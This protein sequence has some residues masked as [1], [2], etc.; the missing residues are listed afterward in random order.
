MRGPIFGVLILVTVVV[1]VLAIRWPFLWVVEALLG[2]LWALAI[3]DVRQR[4]H[5]ILRNFPLLG[6]FR[7][8][9]EMIRPEIQQYFVEGA[10]DGTPFNRERRSVVY[11]RAKGELDTLPFGTQW[12]VYAD[13]YEWIAH[14]MMPKHPSEEMPRVVIGA[15]TCKQPYSA[16]I[17]NISAMSY[18]SLSTRA[19]LALNTGARLG[20]FAHNTGEGGVSPYHQKPGG[21][22][23]WQIGTGYFGCRNAQGG[24]DPERFTQQASLPA[25]KMIEV[26][27][28][29]GAKPGHGGILPASKVSEEISAIRGVPMGQD[30]LSP[31]GHSAFHTPAELLHWIEDLRRMSGGKPVGFKLCVGRQEEFMSV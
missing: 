5:A 27:L 31:P 22:L 21:D 4:K 20:G 13:G 9:F 2:C 10:T 14:S 16:S 28:S 23:V 19:I 8:L 11:Q 24:F 3:Y 18:G 7:Y 26:K 1:G 12:N 30:V 17:L 15:E 25:I 29:Q 6:H